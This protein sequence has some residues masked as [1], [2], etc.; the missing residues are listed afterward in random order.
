MSIFDFIGQERTNRRISREARIDR[1]FQREMSSTAYQRAMA[2]MREA[3]LN[4]ILAYSKG[5]ASTPP[6]RA[7]TGFGFKSPTGLSKALEIANIQTAKNQ[8]DKVGSEARQAELKAD[9][10]QL[11][12]DAY[13]RD[14][15]SPSEAKFT[16]PNRWIS[17]GVANLVQSA[18]ELKDAYDNNQELNK[19]EGKIQ[20][21][22]KSLE[23]TNISGQGAGNQGGADTNVIKI[24]RPKLGSW[25]DWFYN[26]YP[27]DKHPYLYN[28]RTSGGMSVFT[29]KDPSRARKKFQNRKNK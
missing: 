25:Q 28:K 2:D 1:D 4:P 7:A 22:N 23:N 27:P 24:P 11:D 18:R 6:G 14:N 9:M 16:A 3:G 12:Y 20:N 15:V 21:L 5:G 26:Q 13:K 10:D 8:A 17:A 19:L 29:I